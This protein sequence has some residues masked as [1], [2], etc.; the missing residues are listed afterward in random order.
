MSAFI[1]V[2]RRRMSWLTVGGVTVI[3]IEEGLYQYIAIQIS[4]IC[5]LDLRLALVY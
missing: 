3:G 1:D 5:H 2:V 4:Y